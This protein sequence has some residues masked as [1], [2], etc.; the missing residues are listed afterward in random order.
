[1]MQ[2]LPKDIPTLQVSSSRNWTWPDNV[3]GTKIMAEWVMSCVTSPK[4]QGPNT[5]HLPILT[6]VDLSITMLTSQPNQNYREVDWIRFNRRLK[7]ELKTL[8]PPRILASKGEFQASACGIK[9]AL[10]C[11]TEAEVPQTQPH[12]HRKRWWNSDLTKLCND[13]KMLSKALYTFRALPNHPRHRL[14][15]EKQRSMT[16]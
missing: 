6:Q 5:D 9:Q 12:P 1:M 15:K 8:G 3:F 14:Q 16:K 11:T 13:L 4:D 2:L 10:Q 7:A